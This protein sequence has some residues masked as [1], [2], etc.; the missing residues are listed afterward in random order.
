M[1][2]FKGLIEESGVT[3]ARDEE[4]LQR[5]KVLHNLIVK[6]YA[7]LLDLPLHI[8]RVCPAPVKGLFEYF[9]I[10]HETP[11]CYLDIAGG[12]SYTTPEIE[13]PPRTYPK[14]RKIIFAA[15]S[16][17][18]HI[19]ETVT[20]VARDLWTILPGKK[21]P[22]LIQSKVGGLPNNR[23]APTAPIELEIIVNDIV[24]EVM[25]RS[26]LIIATVIISSIIK[27]AHS[28]G[29]SSGDLSKLWDTLDRNTKE[30]LGAKFE[31]YREVYKRFFH[32]LKG[33]MKFFTACVWHFWSSINL[34]PPYYEAYKEI[35]KYLL[36]GTSNWEA[37][38]L[39]CQFE[40]SV[41]LR[42]KFAAIWEF[43]LNSADSLTMDTVWI[44]AQ[45]PD[46]I[47][48]NVA[49]QQSKFEGF[50]EQQAKIHP[51]E[52]HDE[53]FE[54]CELMLKS[55]PGM[56][57]RMRSKLPPNLRR[58][59][60]DV[61]IPHIARLM[62]STIEENVQFRSSE[63]A[64]NWKEKNWGAHM[65]YQ[66]KYP[67]CFLPVG[68]EDKYQNASNHRVNT[69]LFYQ[70]HP[71]SLVLETIQLNVELDF[72]NPPGYN[73]KYNPFE[74]SAMHY[75]QYWET[76]FM[77]LHPKLRAR[78][79]FTNHDL[80]SPAMKTYLPADYVFLS[81]V[82][83]Y[84]NIL[85]ALPI[86]TGKTKELCFNVMIANGNWMELTNFDMVQA[87]KVYLWSLSRL[88]DRRLS[89]F[90]WRHIL[91]DRMELRF[92]AI[93][94]EESIGLNV[95]YE[96]FCEFLDD[97]FLLYAFPRYLSIE[98]G[99]CYSALS[100]GSIFS[101]AGAA[102]V[103]F[104]WFYYLFD[105]L[106]SEILKTKVPPPRKPA[107]KPGKAR[108]SSPVSFNVSAFSLE[109]SLLDPRREV[110]LNRYVSSKRISLFSRLY[111]SKADA[112][113]FFVHPDSMEKFESKY[114]NPT[115]PLESVYGNLKMHVFSSLIS[116]R[117]NDYSLEIQ[118]PE[119]KF[120]EFCAENYFVL[121][122]Q[123]SYREIVQSFKLK[124]FSLVNLPEQPSTCS[125][126]KDSA[127]VLGTFVE[128]A[129]SFG[130]NQH[131]KI[132]KVMLSYI[133]PKLRSNLGETHSSY[134]S[135]LST[136]AESC[137]RVGEDSLVKNYLEQL[138]GV[139]ERIYRKNDLKIGIDCL[140]LAEVYGRLGSNTNKRVRLLQAFKIL[141][142]NPQ[143]HV[144]FLRTVEL[145]KA[146]AHSGSKDE[147]TLREDIIKISQSRKEQG[148]LFVKDRNFQAA[149]EN[150]S[151]ALDLLE[152]YSGNDI[153]QTRLAC[154]LNL[155][156]AHLKLK[157]YD[158]VITH[159]NLALQLD[160]NNFKAHYR[161]GEA[162]FA[163]RDYPNA[164]I[165]YEAVFVGD[166]ANAEAKARLATLNQ[167]NKN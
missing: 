109:A 50:F 106:E 117:L 15:S 12:E 84:S 85:N 44:K 28:N 16:D 11:S 103:P 29:R 46:F 41:D 54:M 59:T 90:G 79:G 129:S 97:L 119:E 112:K 34:A 77:L 164:K 61:I 19:L 136:L 52:D 76:Y 146:S 42:S 114:Q 43:W 115:N 107:E 10:G 156:L 135:S 87:S 130:K 138:L 55:N 30:C 63:E 163:T 25:A 36:E 89:F 67:C 118:L 96:E 71:E 122:V 126:D 23:R 133:L 78:I 108:F 86:Y 102:R 160:A 37:H 110:K 167:L 21:P 8:T 68:F 151:Q 93:P 22:N 100:L 153:D 35:L 124:K 145:L 120:Q 125:V 128:L 3:E 127:Q 47:P 81:N 58:A 74:T 91:L 104:Q 20:V 72:L 92:Q 131:W 49:A 165:S 99:D 159:A 57:E 144:R 69:S 140:R 18:R 56:V 82:P 101:L 24:P 53:T 143:E 26:L 166:P 70:Q 155:A 7:T 149:Q 141:S 83:D 152:G 132:Q 73:S 6:Q 5:V 88:D 13:Q 64:K 2:T 121:L 158:L 60:S 14:S 147:R 39:L 75:I 51:P 38:P 45:S 139:E 98:S 162:Y 27:S 65:K 32:L 137:E 66:R 1:E 62:M 157:N 4:L 9:P 123:P 48:D 111:Q 154:H 150:Y 94:E 105:S 116:I 161:K 95:S 80:N 31:R 33:K 40:V 113:I 148:N 17:P 134:L 142:E